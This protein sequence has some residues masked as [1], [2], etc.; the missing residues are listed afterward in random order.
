MEKTSIWDIIYPLFEITPNKYNNIIVIFLKNNKI[1]KSGKVNN[2]KS[3]NKIKQMR[4]I[5]INKSV[6]KIAQKFIR[7]EKKRKKTCNRKIV[8][9]FFYFKVYIIEKTLPFCFC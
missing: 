2:G 8:C 1:Y 9:W 4:K 5:P 7:N 6:K 3:G